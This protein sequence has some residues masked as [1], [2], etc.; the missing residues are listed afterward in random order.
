MR[1]VAEGLWC[2][3]SDVGSRGR[4]FPLYPMVGQ[5]SGRADPLAPSF[6]E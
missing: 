6:P 1:D 4:S 3:A 2:G 5:Q